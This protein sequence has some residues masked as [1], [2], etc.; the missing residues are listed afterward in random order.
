MSEHIEADTKTKRPVSPAFANMTPERKR[1]VAAMG[2]RALHASG[3]AHIFTEDEQR[4]GAEAA[5]KMVSQ[6]REHMAKIGRLG[7]T[8]VSQDREHMREIGR[9]G[10]E[11][12]AAKKAAK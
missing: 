10:R 5:G 12:Q 7:G 8:S 1:E 3:K 6:D 4:A 11:Q 9:R 2:A